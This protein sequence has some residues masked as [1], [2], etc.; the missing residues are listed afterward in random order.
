MISNS[1]DNAA[2]GAALRARAA[3]STS[4]TGT[5]DGGGSV[6]GGGTGCVVVASPRVEILKS[7]RLSL[8]LRSNNTGVSRQEH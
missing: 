3:I 6:P 4:G 5:A 1:I 7:Q 8:I 2:L